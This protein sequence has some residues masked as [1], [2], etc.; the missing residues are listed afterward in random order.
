[1]ALINDLKAALRTTTTDAGIVGEIQ[2][3]IDAAKA[4]LA[5]SG[6]LAVDETDP[7][8]KRAITTY[9]KANFGYDNPDAD[10]FAKS[11]EMLKQHLSLA[12]DYACY[13]VVFTVTAEGL[14][15][16]DALITINENDDDAKETNSQGVAVFTTKQTGIDFN[17][18]VIKAGYDS[19]A[20]TVYVDGNESV[21]VA[22]SAT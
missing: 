16:D 10:R 21:G 15:V 5:L 22:L 13:A 8:I 19:V 1:M 20:G 2:D 11:Y 6:V 18:A 14:P 17:Y 3:L 9:C 12:T 4:D 7:L